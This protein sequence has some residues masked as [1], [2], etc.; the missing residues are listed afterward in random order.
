MKTVIL[1]RLATI[2][3]SVQTAPFSRIVSPFLP[4]WT[5][6]GISPIGD[7]S[8]HMPIFIGFDR[9]L[10][11]LITLGT[12]PTAGYCG[13]FHDSFVADF[14]ICFEYTKIISIL[15]LRGYSSHSEK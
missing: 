14:V 3:T 12:I 5:I 6:L 8:H 10:P 9:V 1:S 11:Q 15:T 7:N 13:D 4:Q 2:G